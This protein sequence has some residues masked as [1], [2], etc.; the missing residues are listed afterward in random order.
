M[1]VNSYEEAVT[2]YSTSTA[3]WRELERTFQDA[4]VEMHRATRKFRRAQTRLTE[5]E[6]RVGKAR[7]VI[8]K[9]GFEQ[10]LRAPRIVS[11]VNSRHS[12]SSSK[13]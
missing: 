13:S 8:R 9:S 12:M 7:N 10:V 1:I 11:R 3:E 6:L 5:A 4:L 2:L